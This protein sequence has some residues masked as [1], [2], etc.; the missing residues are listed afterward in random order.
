[1]G[2][3]FGGQVRAG[4]DEFLEAEQSGRMVGTAEDAADGFGGGGALVEADT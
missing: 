3:E 1:M 4:G 2:D